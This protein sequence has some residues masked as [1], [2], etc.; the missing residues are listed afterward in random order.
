MSLHLT[1]KMMANCRAAE[2]LHM[3]PKTAAVTLVV[4]MT[5][6]TMWKV[7]GPVRALRA[8]GRV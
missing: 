3:P 4:S 7:K 8:R 5:A 1:S 6:N 2:K